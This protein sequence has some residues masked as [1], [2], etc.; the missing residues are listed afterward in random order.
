MGFAYKANTS[1]FRNTKVIELYHELK[2]FG[3]EVDIYD[4]FVNLLA[5]KKIHNITLLK[6]FDVSNYDAL[7]DMNK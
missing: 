3:I 4:E 2:S 6:C 5:V 7:L 1:D